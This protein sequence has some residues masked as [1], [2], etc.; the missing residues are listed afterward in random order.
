[1]TGINL[2]LVQRTPA[3]LSVRTVRNKLSLGG[4]ALASAL[5]ATPGVAQAEDCTG[6]KSDT[7]LYVNVENVKSA[8]GLIAVTLYADN[9]KKFLAKKGSL[10]VGRVSAKAGTTRVCIYVPAPG[11]YGLAVYHDKDGNRK[12]N[13]NG[14]GMPAEP[15]GFSNNA[16]TFLG[17]PSFKSVRMSVPKDGFQTSV[18]L[19]GD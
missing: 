2:N 17:L 5:A 13:R 10:Y 16:S 14:V 12:F 15:Y 19:K 18:K 4:I 7:K 9:S 6:T 1:M 11:T 3:M 8:Q